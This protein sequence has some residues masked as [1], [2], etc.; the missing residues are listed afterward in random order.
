[1]TKKKSNA[2]RPTKMTEAT[3]QKLREAF[4]F[5]ASDLQACLY[6]EIC[7]S[8]L[9]NYQEENK[10]FLDM[11]NRLKEN[12]RL[13]AKRNISKAVI[14][15]SDKEMSKYVLDRTDKDFKPKQD[16][17][18]DGTIPVIVFKPGQEKDV[19]KVKDL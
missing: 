6:A 16:L 11:K 9:Y 17:G 1:M 13:H 7:S 10:E 8:T 14:E 4:S 3:L 19:E 15:D 2:G 5:G 12:V 18:V